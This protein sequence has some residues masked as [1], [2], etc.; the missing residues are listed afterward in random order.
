MSFE[1]IDKFIADVQSNPE[2]TKAVTEGGL[3][4]GLELAREL[5]YDFTEEEA[6][7]YLK[8]LGF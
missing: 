2:L 3:A 4:K 7:E 1:Q 6:K 8:K 5:G